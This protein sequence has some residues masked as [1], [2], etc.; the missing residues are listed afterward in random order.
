MKL[1]K[2][3]KIIIGVVGLGI[4]AYATKKYW[5]PKKKATST[6]PTGNVSTQSAPTST[7]APAPATTSTPTKLSREEMLN[8]LTQPTGGKVEGG[9]MSM[10]FDK[11]FFK[12][13]TDRELEVMI[14]MG[15]LDK[16]QKPKSEEDALI[17]MKQKGVSKEDFNNIGKKMQNA[18]QGK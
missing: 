15:E 18:F 17:I 7:P 4:L 2:N 12:N 13:F 6:N 10:D 8:K 16:M 1:T 14:V 9:S 11:S 5:M 3:H